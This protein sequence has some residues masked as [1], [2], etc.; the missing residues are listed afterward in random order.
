MEKDPDWYTRI[1]DRQQGVV[2]VDGS[3]SNLLLD[4]TGK[5]WTT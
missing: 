3:L 5:E 1:L 4:H 2:S